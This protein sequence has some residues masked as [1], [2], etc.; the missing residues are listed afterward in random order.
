MTPSE[1]Q[2]GPK[3]KNT[4]TPDWLTGRDFLPALPG[5]FAMLCGASNPVPLRRPDRCLRQGAWG[6]LGDAYYPARRYVFEEFEDGGRAMPSYFASA[7]WAG[8]RVTD[9]LPLV[10]RSGAQASLFCSNQI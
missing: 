10:S 6:R 3:L 1:V 2:S 4:L 9:R 5:A 7:G 8:N